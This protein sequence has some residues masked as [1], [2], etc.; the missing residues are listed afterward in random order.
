MSKQ[1]RLQRLNNRRQGLYDRGG[2]VLLSKSA[3]PSLPPITEKYAGL[4]EPESVKYAIGAMQAVDASYTDISIQE[5]T[6][7]GERLQEG[8]DQH[9]TI[10]TQLQGSVPLDVH[11]RGNSDVDLL[12]VHEEF[13]TNDA[14]IDL[15]R[16]G[17]TTSEKHPSAV[18]SLRDMRKKAVEILQTRYWGAKVDS[19]GAKAI[20]L[21]EGSFR[22]KVDVVP[23]HWHNTQKWFDTKDYAYR[24]V[25]ILDNHAGVTIDNRPF[26]HIRNVANKCAL[27]GGGLRKVIR[28][29][30]NLKYDADAEIR[31]SSYDIA[32]I[33]YHMSDA[34]LRRGPYLD[35]QLLGTAAA[36]L[37]TIITNDDYRKSLWVP[38]G[39]RQIFDKPEKLSQTIALFGELHSLADEVRQAISP[40]DTQIR[41]DSAQKQIFV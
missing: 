29:L 19:T 38:D 9:T 22:R 32:S 28:L 10:S 24:Y 30:K 20:T 36:H 18:N 12:L 40:Y 14:N 31:L 8:F 2:R 33:A 3:A 35:L 16:H 23:S 7:V 41:L 34:L 27:V 5:G 11:V 25:N 13:V 6:R 17:M 4:S 1:D 15:A 39:S 21:S 37:A 26:L